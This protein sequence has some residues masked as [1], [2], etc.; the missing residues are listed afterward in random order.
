MLALFEDMLC[1]LRWEDPPIL[2]GMVDY[3]APIAALA[4]LTEEI[5]VGSLILIHCHAASDP[6]RPGLR[7]VRWCK[8]AL[9][10]APSRAIESSLDST[11]TFSAQGAIP[12]VRKGL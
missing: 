4:Q 7:D 3:A 10:R 11:S 8:A 2:I 9:P 1:S 12:A 6:S 5:Q